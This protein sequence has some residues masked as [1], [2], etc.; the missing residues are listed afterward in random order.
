MQKKSKKRLNSKVEPLA[1]VSDRNG[2]SET[3]LECRICRVPEAKSNRLLS[4]F[5]HNLYEIFNELTQ[6]QV[7]Y[8]KSM[9]FKKYQ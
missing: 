7:R 4:L 3:G 1:S 8:K 6:I 5:E 9:N 2:C